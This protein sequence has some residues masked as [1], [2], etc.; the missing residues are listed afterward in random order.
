MGRANRIA[1]LWAAAAI[2]AAGC[3]ELAFKDAVNIQVPEKAIHLEVH[4]NA[5]VTSMP[6]L[7]VPQGFVTFEPGA[8]QFK[9]DAPVQQD[10]S[11]GKF[12]WVAVAISGVLLLFIRP[13]TQWFRRAGRL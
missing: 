7:D 10:I 5:V 13:P 3:G 12:G 1:G 8:F 2:A 11:L 6:A 9:L 4:P